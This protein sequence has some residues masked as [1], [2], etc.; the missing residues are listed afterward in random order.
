MTYIDSR[1]EELREIHSVY[2]HDISDSICELANLPDLKR[3]SM[4]DKNGGVLF[5]SFNTFNYRYSRLDHSFGVA[6]I[7]E[8]FKQDKCHILEAMFHEIQ[9]A[10][11]AYSV[12]YLINYF[13]IKDFQKPKAFEKIISSVDS[14]KDYVSSS[15]SLE[16]VSNYKDYSLGFADF[17]KMS[18]ENLEYVLSNSYFSGLYDLM[19][20]E[21]FYNNISICKN[22]DNKDEFCFSDLYLAY[23]F[24]KLS[25]EIGK[26]NRSYEA[27]I[28]RQLISDVIMLMIRRE[29]IKFEDLFD[30]TDKGI[31]GIGKCCSDKRIKEGWEAIENL[32]KVDLKFN[33]SFDK[34]KYC[35]KTKEKSIYI[36]PLVKTKA[37][38]YRLSSLDERVD[39]DIDAYLSTDTDMYMCIN[40]EL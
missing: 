25:I 34:T 13:K 36:D 12:D 14:F 6:I 38:I 30:S 28:T 33:Q 1:T 3:I 11:F 19:E 18:A 4:V 7:L 27:K 37:G 32:N 21:E 35:V 40:Y 29:E 5:S 20:I 39:K 2:S 31:R 10:S 22:E 16:D 15:F 26:R 17:P 23:K 9:E 8:H 24:F